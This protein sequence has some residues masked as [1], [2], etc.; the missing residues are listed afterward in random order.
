[1][2]RVGRGYLARKFWVKMM[3][4]TLLAQATAQAAAMKERFQLVMTMRRRFKKFLKP[5]ELVVVTGL[6]KRLDL[7]LLHVFSEKRRQL[8]FTSLPRLICFDENLESIEWEMPWSLAVEIKLKENPKEFTV[9]DGNQKAKFLDVLGNAARWKA[10]MGHTQISDGTG[11]AIFELVKSDDY[12]PETMLRFQGSLIKRSIHTEAGSAR[13]QKR[14]VALSGKTL[15]WFKSSDAPS[16]QLEL[17]P[18]TRINEY[19]AAEL[20]SKPKEQKASVEAHP[21]AI[22]VMTPELK[23]SGLDGLVLQV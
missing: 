8:V 11:S 7:G 14:W 23:Q 13:W 17:T 18:G 19:S 3:K 20:A 9:S 1:M 10:A 15:F 6:V 21:H 4:A 12:Q 22:V 5:Q 2:Q 16:G